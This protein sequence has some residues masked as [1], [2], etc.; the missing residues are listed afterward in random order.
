MAQNRKFQDFVGNDRTDATMQKHAVFLYDFTV[1]GGDIGA[2]TLT[3]I[4]GN[5]ATLPASAVITKV[6][7]DN[8]GAPASVGSATIAL[9]VTGNTDAFKAATAFDNAAYTAEATHMHNEV[10]LKVGL[11]AVSVLGTIATAALIAG[12]FRIIVE[13][14]E[15]SAV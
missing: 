1:Q 12:K 4:Y 13:Y 7:Y 10:P 9:G 14:T 15:S 8:Q 3:D 5:A 2:V 11:A 6:T